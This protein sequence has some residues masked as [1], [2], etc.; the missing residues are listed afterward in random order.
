MEKVRVGVIGCGAISNA[1]FNHAKLYPDLLDVAAVA[2]INPDAAKA[3]AAE[4][5]IAKVLTVKQLLKDPSIEIV[6]NL[7]IPAAHADIALAALKAG[8]HT[9]S[10][11]P[12]DISVAKGKRIVKLANA[13]NLRVG[14]APDTFFGAGH[15][16]ARKLIDDGVIGKPLVATA[17]MMGHGHESWH[18][19]PVFYYKPGGGPMFDMGPYYLTAM[20]NMLGPIS[21]VTGMADIMIPER[22][23]THKNKEGGPGPLFGQKIA[24]ET[25][26]HVA[27]TIKFQ[28]GV[29]GTIITTFAIW[30]GTHD[31]KN[32][33]TIYGTEGTMKVPDPNGF[34]G[35]VFVR[36][37]D[38]SDWRQVP[39][40][41]AKGFG[42]M[43]G[44]A[45]MAMAIRNNRPHRASLEQAF[46]VLDAMDG[47]LKSSKTGKVHNLTTD[48]QRPAMLPTWATPGKLD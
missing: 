6:L 2:D 35:D 11:K 29:I 25:P 45:D 8:K 43:V 13:K 42:R 23:I 37:H 31:G 32:P 39:H 36:R 5:N 16:T 9:Y 41:H 1:Y 33:I 28:S 10:E 48:Y 15:Q 20:I 7:T 24:V 44:V 34:D 4:H 26:D 14:C 19:S 47:F 18:P 27:G 46:A 21:A 17:Y 12:L 40:T 22:T 30:H 38:E 3:K